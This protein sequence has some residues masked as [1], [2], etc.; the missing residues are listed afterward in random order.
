MF[1]NKL[2]G[3]ILY[4]IGKLENLIHLFLDINRLTG[5][6]PEIASKNL[7]EFSIPES[8]HNLDKL[9]IL[10]LD[11]TLLSGSISNF[12]SKHLWEMHLNENYLTGT[13]PHDLF[14]ASGLEH[15]DVGSNVL[16]GINP[17][18]ILL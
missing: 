1:Y 4:Q 15:I 18:F 13:L 10:L 14:Q 5:I 17:Q 2:H 6:F 7:R 11:L 9:E 3:A 8:I 12:S 16:S